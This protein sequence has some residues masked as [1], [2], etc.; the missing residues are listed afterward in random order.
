[1]RVWTKLVMD[2][3]GTV[4]YDESE[5]YE[6]EG[7]VA[8]MKGGGP[9]QTIQKADPWA[10]AQPYIRGGL[11]EAQRLY[12]EQRPEYYYGSTVADFTPG[13]ELALNTMGARAM[14]G[15]PLLPQSQQLAM[16]T[17]GGK[18]M[19]GDE[20]M[21]AYGN[22]I[23]DAVSSQFAKAGRFG[24]GYHARTA[25]DQ[26]GSKALQLY[27]SERNR[28]Q[29]AMQMA[30][31]LA[32][33]DYADI[34]RLRAAFAPYDQLNQAKLTDDVNR[35]DFY[36]NRDQQALANYM[37]M[38]MGSGGLGGTSS[39]MTPS[40]S[41]GLTGALGGAAMGAGLAGMVPGAM[42]AAGALGPLGWGMVG[43]GA[44]GGLL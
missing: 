16:D 12:Q 39:S 23:T 30:P 4:H 25:A 18:F 5:W 37:N 28:Q 43:M 21:R 34:D 19:G 42:T 38:A 29:Q 10:G 1:M 2:W 40:S 20:F 3:D 9:T 35:W 7:P 17:M 11:Q 13:T 14:A 32:Q 8:E 44:L 6:Y 15:N 27:D 24:S 22:D 36:Q 26:L 41:G 31:A 33:A